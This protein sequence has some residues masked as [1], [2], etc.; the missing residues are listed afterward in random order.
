MNIKLSHNL[1]N[2]ITYTV[3]LATILLPFSVAFTNILWAFSLILSFISP[4]WWHGLKILYKQ[5]KTLTLIWIAYIFLMIVG[6][7]WSP[8]LSRG[9]TIISKQ[10]S[11][12]IIPM[13]ITIH[14]K[15]IW[16]HHLM[17]S[18][19]IGLGL[20]LLLCIAQSQGV[21]L[22]VTPPLGSS[23]QDP[24]GLIGHIGFGLVYGIWAAWLVHIGWLTEN[25]TRYLLWGVAFVATIMIFIVQGRSGYLVALALIIIMA[26]KLWLQHLNAKLLLIMIFIG[27]LTIITVISGPAKNRIDMTLNS[28]QS[29]SQGDFKHAEVRISMWYVSWQAWKQSPWL[30]IGTGGFPSVSHDIIK[31]H[32]NL[33]LA[34][35]T[36][37][38]VPHNI[39]IMELTR[40]G[41]LGLIVLLL[42]LG[43][44]IRMGWK[45]DWRQPHHLLIALSGIALSVHGLT[46]QSIEE[47]HASIYT[48]IFLSI[49]LARIHLLCTPQQI[50][51]MRQEN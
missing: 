20:H 8:D 31:Q 10:W 7:L 30:G 29:F 47:Y 15:K 17:L 36:S 28:L 23:M 48:A 2:I 49:G 33:N 5:A 4:H 44:W 32:P 46:S 35:D 43:C 40:W 51:Y 6:L 13:L 25:K 12:L 45:V 38:A 41:P 42:F 50:S 14:Q 21:P 19:S 34:G 16:Q 26:W 1:P 37:F 18:I 22:P 24:A 11:W 9:L 39:Y 27:F 3:C